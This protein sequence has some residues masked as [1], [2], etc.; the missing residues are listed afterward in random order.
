MPEDM[1]LRLAAMITF[2]GGKTQAGAQGEHQAAENV[3]HAFS[4]LYDESSRKLESQ[5]K[6]VK[7]V[8]PDWLV[9]SLL[10]N[11]LV[12]ETPY[13]PKYLKN[14][15]ELADLIRSME[16]QGTFEFYVVI[17]RRPNWKFNNLIIVQTCDQ[18]F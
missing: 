4:V 12:D 6:H 17:I 1:S 9:D 3:T 5:A 15:P 16:E 11:K 2:Y 8:T 14:N 13:H 10:A 7:L 18:I